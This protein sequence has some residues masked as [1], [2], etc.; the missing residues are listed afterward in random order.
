MSFKKLFYSFGFV[1]RLRVLP[2]LLDAA[3]DEDEET[4]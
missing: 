4:E 2:S 3:E 1:S